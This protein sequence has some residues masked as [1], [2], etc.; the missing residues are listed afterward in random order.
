MMHKRILLNRMMSF[1]TKTS[2]LS[3]YKMMILPYF[4]YCD[5]IYQTTC[6]S[7]LDKL[8][9]LQ[10]KCLKTCLGL[11]R[12]HNT[13]EVHSMAKC[14]YLGP[15]RKGH[16]CNFMYKR[17]SKAELMDGRNINTRQHDAPL[18]RVT[19]PSKEA[20]KRS[21]QY[22]GSLMWNE[23][24]VNVR[25]LDNYIVFKARQKSLMSASYK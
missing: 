7:D 21:V 1:L 2:A 4:D 24:P 20:F 6:M 18:F 11:N 16:V 5:V 10:N 25:L 3:I 19:H 15:R 8:Q 14:A 9:R 22:A 17:Q 23:L 13:K 12:L